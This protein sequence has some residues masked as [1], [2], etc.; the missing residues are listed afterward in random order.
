MRIKTIFIKSL[1]D[2]VI[3][4]KSYTVNIIQS[5]DETNKIVT[6]SANSINDSN[7][8]QGLMY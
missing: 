4:L 6:I 1:K 2:Y 8:L 5:V 7:A 3:K